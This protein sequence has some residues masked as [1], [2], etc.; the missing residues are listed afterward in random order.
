MVQTMS[1]SSEI[2]P[3]PSLIHPS[4]MSTGAKRLERKRL[5]TQRKL[6][7]AI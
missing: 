1:A 6:I 5:C 7:S 2:H 4:L 3:I